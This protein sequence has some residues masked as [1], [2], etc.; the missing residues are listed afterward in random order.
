MT[1][2]D[3]NA[4]HQARAVR[5]P[6][7]VV[8]AAGFAAFIYPSTIAGAASIACSWAVGIVPFEEVR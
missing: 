2:I 6:V 4:R 3:D 1:A 5:D 7:A 8:D